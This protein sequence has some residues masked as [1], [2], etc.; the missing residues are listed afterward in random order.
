M[1]TTTHLLN[2]SIQGMT[3][4]AAPATAEPKNQD[5]AALSLRMGRSRGTE[6]SEEALEN[7]KQVPD[8]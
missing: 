2:P 4:V 1:N 6:V 3:A 8:R 7:V 5:S